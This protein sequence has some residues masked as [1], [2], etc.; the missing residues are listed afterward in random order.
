M[1]DGGDILSEPYRKLLASPPAD[2]NPYGYGWRFST[3][4][5]ETYPYHVGAT[6][7]YRAE[8]F[9]MPERGWGAVL[10][11]NKFHELEAGP[12]LS[13]MDGIRSIMDDGKAPSLAEMDHTPQWILLGT[14]FLFAGLAVLDLLRLNR[15]R[16]IRRLWRLLSSLFAILIAAALIPLFS[17]NIGIP[18]R[19]VGLFA[20]DIAWLIRILIAI[21]AVYGVASIVLMARRKSVQAASDEPSTAGQGGVI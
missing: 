18:W 10:L 11:T 4:N 17:R 3:W 15:Q 21:L 20:P 12:Y 19:S 8:I 16:R 13:M 2:G 7:D 1:M 6:P 5:G 9:F 14:D